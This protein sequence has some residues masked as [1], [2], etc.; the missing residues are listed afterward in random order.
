MQYKD[1]YKTLGVPRGATADAIKK[2]YRLLARK[3]HPDVSKEANAEEKFKEVAEAYEVLKDPEKRAAYDQL[4]TWQPGQDFRPPPD[5]DRH[6]RGFRFESGG[7]GGGF[8]FSDFFS[9]LFGGAATGG[10]RAQGFATRGQDVEATVELT[11]QQAL[12]GTEANFQLAVPEMDASGH[13]HR[14]PRQI[15]ARIPR[16]VSDGQVMRVPGKGGR[17][18]GGAPDGD[19][20][21]KISFR[22]HAL[23]RAVEHDLYIEVPVTPWEAALGATVDIPTLDGHARLKISAGVRAG[24]K[25]R[26]AGKGLPKPG[27][28][29]FGDLFAVLQIAVPGSLTEKEK[30]LF[31]DLA[32]CSRF[33]PRRHFGGS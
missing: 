12:H 8:D 16:G 30:S 22:P 32:R 3:Y 26:L 4:G 18:F 11:L 24:Q 1:Y 20:Y 7:P 28:H 10:R 13:L 19:L 25:L 14:T 31:E 2:A 23:F 29:G 27:G 21:L 17:G 9:E 15:K 33:D 6:A 5:W